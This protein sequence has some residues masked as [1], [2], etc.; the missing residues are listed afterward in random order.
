MEFHEVIGGVD[1]PDV[2]WEQDTYNWWTAPEQ[3]N[4][5]HRINAL[6]SSVVPYKTQLL[7]V[8][9]KFYDW[10]MT[11]GDDN[12]LFVGWPA[13]YDYPYIQ[14][15]FKAAGL[16]NPF[17][18]RTV[19]VK[20][21]ACGILDLPFDAPR[22]AFPEWFQEKPELPHDALSDAIAQAVVFSRLLVHRE[23]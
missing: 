13:S 14:L 2:E 1:T 12:L 16:P 11:L 8:A 9:D 6:A 19:D 5:K 10:L 20:S 3:E 15:L 4:A 18:Y 23:E 7:N 21:F 22:D 17:S